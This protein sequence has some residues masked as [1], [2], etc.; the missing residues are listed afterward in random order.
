MPY[1][2][3]KYTPTNGVPAVPPP[4]TQYIASQQF[5]LTTAP[6]Q[7][8]LQ[9]YPMA[10]V[11]TQQCPMAMAQTQQHPPEYAQHPPPCSSDT[12]KI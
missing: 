5:P 11:Q 10:M 3:E 9:Q 4:P 6:T 12:E 2:I 1:L 7:Q 8:Y